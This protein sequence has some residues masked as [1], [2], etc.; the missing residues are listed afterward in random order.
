MILET[1]LILIVISAAIFSAGSAFVILSIVERESRAAR[2]G[3]LLTLT[4]TGLL[5]ICLLL[6]ENITLILIIGILGL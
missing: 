6:P 3:F 4:G 1:S 5:L 2:R